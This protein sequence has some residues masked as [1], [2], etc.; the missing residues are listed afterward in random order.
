MVR[1]RADY[2]VIEWRD[3]K[4]EKNLIV[5]RDEVAKQTT[6]RAGSHRDALVS[7]LINLI[8]S[9]RSPFDVR[10]GESLLI[11]LFKTRANRT[12]GLS[13]SAYLVRRLGITPANERTLGTPTRPYADTPKRSSLAA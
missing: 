8:I 11:L 12:L 13:L 6:R 7:G 10:A 1:E 4:W 2:P 3:F 5:V 9:R